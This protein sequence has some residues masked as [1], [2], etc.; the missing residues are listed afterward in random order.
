MENIYVTKDIGLAAALL[1]EGKKISEIQKKNN[2][3]WFYFYNLG[4]CIKLDKKYWFGELLVNARIYK[5]NLNQLKTLIH[6]L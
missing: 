2:I 1:S 4:D 6:D 3:C 5:Q